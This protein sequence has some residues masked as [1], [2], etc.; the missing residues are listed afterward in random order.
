MPPSLLKKSEVLSAKGAIFDF[1]EFS[2]V[3]KGELGPLF[4]EAK[5][6]E[7]KYTNKDV[8]ILTA[9]PAR[10]RSRYNGIFKIRRF[11][12]TY[13]KHCRS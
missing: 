7:G 1:R 12:N 8:F 3:M 11:G 13:R 4:S 10:R 2:Q 5:K 6:K 9:R